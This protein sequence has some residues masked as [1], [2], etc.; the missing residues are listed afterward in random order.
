MN[1]QVGLHS[2]A[3]VSRY[4]IELP[5][6]PGGFQPKVEL[7][8]NSGSVDEMKNK[9]SMGS[10]VGIGWTLHLGRISLD[11][12]YG[13]YS[14]DLNGESY[15]IVSADGAYYTKPD[16]FFRITRAGQTWD[17]WDRGGVKYE[18]GG[19]ADSQQYH[20]TNQYY[21]WDLNLMQDTHGNQITVSYVRDI[22][23]ECAFG[24]S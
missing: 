15:E 18:F 9:R 11:E 5:P 10:W 1:F 23:G 19:T 14:L 17:I 7:V 6:G 20:D 21:R 2:G 12:E 24:L 8:Y 4:P 3:A 16:M 22:V 13:S